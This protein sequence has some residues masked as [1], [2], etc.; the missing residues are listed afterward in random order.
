[1]FVTPSARHPQVSAIA[2]PDT[3]SETQEQRTGRQVQLCRRMAELAMHLAEAAAQQALS[4]AD[5]EAKPRGPNPSVTF[6]R[7]C[8]TI[9]QSIALEAKLTAAPKTPRSSTAPS[10]LAPAPKVQPGP[11]THKKPPATEA[12]IHQQAAA[13]SP[14][15]PD[16]SDLVLTPVFDGKT[17]TPTYLPRAAVHP[18][19]TPPPQPGWTTPSE[20]RATDPPLPTGPRWAMLAG[21]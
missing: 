18:G 15:E 1:M 2:D 16:P 4:H 5:D 19:P 21:R 17:Y 6:I 13:T 12:P 9:R 3:A 14:A 8:T 11:E 7:L 20:R 10:R